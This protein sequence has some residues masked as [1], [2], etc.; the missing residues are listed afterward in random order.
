MSVCQNSPS[1]FHCLCRT[2]QTF[3]YQTFAFPSSCEFLP[4]E[5][6]NHYPQA[7][8]FCLQLKT[9]LK[10][11]VLAILVRYSVFLGLS[12]VIK[13]CLIFS[14]YS[15]SHQFNSSTSQKNLDGQ[16]KNFFLL[17]TLRH[18]NLLM[19]PFQSPDLSGTPSSAKVKYRFRNGAGR[20]YL[21]YLQ[22]VEIK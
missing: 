13:L 14:C 10:A 21:R 2:Q 22:F 8:S 6:P 9:E 15:V 19:H 7:P 18:L 17:T 20:A 1:A 16:R 4:S 12:H 11:S 3:V 5:V